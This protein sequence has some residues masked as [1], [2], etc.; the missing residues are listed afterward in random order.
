MVRKFLCFC[1]ILCALALPLQVQCGANGVDS[2]GSFVMD[3]A[4]CGKVLR[5]EI[6]GNDYNMSLNSG[7]AVIVNG[8]PARV[9]PLKYVLNNLGLSGTKLTGM[10]G[11][12]VLL[13]GEGFGELLPAL[14]EL[15]ADVKAID[16][17][18]D[19]KDF[20]DSW[21]GQKMSSYVQ[22]NR[23]YLVSGSAQEMPFEDESFDIV[24]S[25]QLIN[26]FDKLKPMARI[27]AESFRVLKFGGV[28]YHA[29]FIRGQDLGKLE[30]LSQKIGPT[31]PSF[32]NIESMS[33][34]YDPASMLGQ[35]YGPDLQEVEP[36]ENAPFS[37]FN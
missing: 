20:P 22:T 17:W 10:F 12:K 23:T 32:S 15:G 21:M 8:V 31:L 26:N 3:E 28:A 30:E 16:L 7:G 18:Y 19:R 1:F 24:I 4:F 13:Q 9:Y 29:G 6:L 33:F 37:R 14:V 25:H 35:E 5:G 34:T 36:L 2:N 11:K 27:I